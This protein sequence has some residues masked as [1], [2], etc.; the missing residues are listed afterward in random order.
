MDT[1]AA[2]AYVLWVLVV[3]ALAY[4]VINTVS[5]VVDLFSS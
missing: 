2:R 1:T 4:G 5:Q 3:A